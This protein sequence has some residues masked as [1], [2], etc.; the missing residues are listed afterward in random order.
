[1]PEEP[2]KDLQEYCAVKNILL[3]HHKASKFSS[4]IT[5][6]NDTVCDILSV[7]ANSMNHPVYV[8]CLDGANITSAV[9]ASLRILQMWTPAAAIVEY[10]RFMRD[11][12]ESIDTEEVNFV[13]SI[14]GSVDITSSC[15]P[16]WLWGGEAPTSHPV[17]ELKFIEGE[18]SE[19]EEVPLDDEGGGG[20]DYKSTLESS[21]AAT[22]LLSSTSGGGGTVA[23]P[24]MSWW[25]QPSILYGKRLL[26]SC[27]PLSFSISI[28]YIIL[29]R[30][31]LSLSLHTHTHSLSLLYNR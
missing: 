21:V 22:A 27:T 13:T 31:Y 8:H 7:L 1:V 11:P 29:L 5:V 15:I 26:R 30:H 12:M 23:P 20:E 19:E 4:F 25:S 10:C 9:I 3:I 24:S 28:A 6:N 2:I 14:H 16:A 18:G 17:F